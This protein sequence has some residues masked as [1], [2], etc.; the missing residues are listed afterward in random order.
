MR[1]ADE[2]IKAVI[3]ADFFI[4]LTEYASDKGKLFCQMM[5]DLGVQPI[6]HK[7]VAEVELKRNL[8]LPQLIKDGNIQVVDYEDYID[9][10][11]DE[12][13]QQYFRWAYEKMNRFDFP[14]GEDI[15][16]YHEMDE[17][18]GE[19][20]SIYLAKQMGCMYF[21]SDDSGARS[22]VRNAFS[23]KRRL[24]TMSVF[25][26]IKQCALCGTSITLKQLGP[27][28]HNVFRERQDKLKEL[29][30]LYGGH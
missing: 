15:Y 8:C 4:K 19:I 2:E 18:L 6:M 3:D 27:T 17:N 24:E 1:M 28:I 13:Y 9:R 29:Q 30:A 25:E 26:A 20:R 12:T 11:N 16:T 7:Y 5:K 10:E 22:F 21:M 14:E 23:S